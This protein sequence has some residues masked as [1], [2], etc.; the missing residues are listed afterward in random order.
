MT[1]QRAKGFTVALALSLGVHGL[2]LHGASSWEQPSAQSR[3]PELVVD[4]YP[5]AKAAPE[6]S[7]EA[8]WVTS[9]PE[10]PRSG[11]RRVLCPAP[12][13]D[14]LTPKRRAGGRQGLAPSRPRKDSLSGSDFD[15]L[16]YRPY[17]HRERDTP[18]ARAARRRAASLDNR[19][20]TP[21]PGRHEEAVV[22]RGAAKLARGRAQRGSSLRSKPG[23]NSPEDARLSAPQRSAGGRHALTARAPS[24]GEARGE[25]LSRAPLEAESASS[26]RRARLARDGRRVSARQRGEPGASKRQAQASKQRISQR[27]DAARPS[28]RGRGVGKKHG[29]VAGRKGSP[30][31]KRRGMPIWLHTRDRRY[32]AYFRKIYAKIQ[33]R[34]R[35]PK[36]LELKLEQGEVLL[37]FVIA[38][39]G[40]LAKVHIRRSSGYAAFD[41]NAVRAVRS[42]APFGP[43]P[44]HL[45]TTELRILAPFEFSN[46]LVR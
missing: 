37:E 10:E 19:S 46:P 12:A 25:H 1:Q 13:L 26:P 35:F 40:A 34:W 6:V 5:A 18:L 28:D 36:T 42:A 2:F 45:A 20:A 38:A 27:I 3:R 15:D 22:R 8:S 44:A 9:P 4:V 21:R 17:D 32:V 33:P 16:R 23:T 14:A 43:I 11:S 29:A 30:M 39:D 24:R 41:R 31:G 7:K